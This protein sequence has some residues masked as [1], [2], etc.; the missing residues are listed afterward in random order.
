MGEAL[1]SML[2][3]ASKIDLSSGQLSGGGGQLSPLV[4]PLMADTQTQLNL[5]LLHQFYKP[6]STTEGK[7]DILFLCKYQISWYLY[8]KMVAQNKGCACKEKTDIK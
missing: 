1:T 8:S 2:S 6:S 3:T 7:I 4:S 5:L